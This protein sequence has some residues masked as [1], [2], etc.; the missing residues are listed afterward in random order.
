MPVRIPMKWIEDGG[1]QQD[2]GGHLED[3]PCMAFVGHT[4]DRK[5]Y[6]ETSTALIAPFFRN[7]GQRPQMR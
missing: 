3:C 1:S 6:R 4:T 2:C 7:Y 5:F